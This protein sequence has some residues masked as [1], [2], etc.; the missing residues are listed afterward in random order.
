MR[1]RRLWGP[2]FL[3]LFSLTIAGPTVGFPLNDD[4]SYAHSAIRLASEGRL[5]LSDWS[6]PTQLMHIW[7]GALFFKIIGTGYAAL[8]LYGVV[9]G[10]LTLYFF[11]RT[12][13]ELGLEKKRALVATA[14]L[15]VC[16]FFPQLSNTFM[17][18]VP[19]LLWSMVSI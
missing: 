5:V 14:T 2:G 12:A 11:H 19:Y 16:P 13:E 1:M 9:A 18:D 6:S 17:T 4:W 15:A 10:A 3:V 7:V 8:R